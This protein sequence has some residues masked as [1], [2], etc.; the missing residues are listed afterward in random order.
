MN[1]DLIIDVSN[2]LTKDWA[3]KKEGAISSHNVYNAIPVLFSDNKPACMEDVLLHLSG[4]SREYKVFT[5]ESIA[6]GLSEV[7]DVAHKAESVISNVEFSPF[8][9][10][11]RDDFSKASKCHDWMNHIPQEIIEIWGDLTKSQRKIAAMVAEKAT[12][13][14][15]WD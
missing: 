13:S 9:S 10:L 8:E 4:K 11:D 3:D 14:E 12:E 6:C 7:L 15:S 2:K 5:L 1:V